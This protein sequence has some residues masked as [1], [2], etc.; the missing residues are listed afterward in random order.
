MGNNIMQMSYEQLNTAYGNRPVQDY[1]TD[2]LIIGGSACGLSAAVRAR[3]NGVERVM[4]LDRG[5]ILGGSARMAVAFWGCNTNAQR[6]FG[7]KGKSMDPD[8]VY[9]EYMDAQNWEVNSKLI[10]RWTLESAENV[11]WLESKGVIFDE[12]SGIGIGIGV[13]GLDVGQMQSGHFSSLRTGRAVVNALIAECERLNVDCRTEVRAFR[14]LQEDGRVCGAVAAGQ[15]VDLRIRAQAVMICTGTVI[16]NKALA[17]QLMPDRNLDF[18]FVSDLPHNQGDGLLMALDAGAKRG[19]IGVYPIG[20]SNHPYNMQ[21]GLISRRP[22]MVWVNRNGERF[23]SEA[24]YHYGDFNWRGGVALGLQPEE[25]CWAIISERALDEMLTNRKLY[26][27]V[28]VF[29]GGMKNK[30]LSAGYG[31]EEAYSLYDSRTAWM[32]EI[33]PGIEA[34]ITAGRCLKAET[35]D[36]IAAWIGADPAVLRKTVE[37]Y[38][39]ACKV[40]YDQEYLKPAKF[41]WPLDSAPYYVFRMN[42]AGDNCVGGITID[43]HFQVLNED[44]RPIPGLYAGGVAASGFV[45]RHYSFGGTCL[46]CALYSGYAGGKI[47]AEFVQSQK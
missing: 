13:D 21:I 10:R 22:Q 41:L 17:K 31:T 30:K 6:R 37:N 3:E 28:E 5:K 35:L 9:E 39:Y 33:R 42:Q 2:I 43:H 29:Q 16:G 19:L 24:K 40:G 8:A 11:N 15:E 23:F 32:D 12:I 25:T 36:E 1:E 38:N 4:V 44:W 46:G 47:M 7:V 20:P 14:L 45:A 27:N 18:Y 26:T 34:E